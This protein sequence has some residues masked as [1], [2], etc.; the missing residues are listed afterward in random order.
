MSQDVLVALARQVAADVREQPRIEALADDELAK[1][2][3]DADEI[4]SIR[5]G[6]FDRVLWLGI[7]AAEDSPGC[8]T[9]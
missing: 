5:S 1:L 6:F 7:S 8:C 2:G 3:L 9:G 4:Q